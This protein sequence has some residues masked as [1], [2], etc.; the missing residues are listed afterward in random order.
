MFYR[1]ALKGDEIK[2]Q[3][4]VDSI[5]SIDSFIRDS[6]SEAQAK[7]NSS[8]ANSLKSLD[9]FNLPQEDLSLNENLT[10]NSSTTVHHH[11]VVPYSVHDLDDP[12][13]LPIQSP[14]YSIDG[15]LRPSFQDN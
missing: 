7:E 12:E 11:F 4:K 10:F 1:N 14:R 6:K 15:H 13:P 2:I 5:A 3:K 8:V 9:N